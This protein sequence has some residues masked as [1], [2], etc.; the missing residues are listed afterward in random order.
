MGPEV[1]ASRFKTQ[2]AHPR[3]ARREPF[4]NV[5]RRLGLADVRAF[6]LAWDDCEQLLARLGYKAKVEVSA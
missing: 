1:C 3:H 6:G 4:E 5:V 2:L